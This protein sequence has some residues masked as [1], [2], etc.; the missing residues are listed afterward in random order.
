[1]KNIPLDLIKQAKEDIGIRAAEIIAGGIGLNKWDTR[2]L[3]GCC[4]VHM[5]KTPSLVWN[6][7][8]NYFKCFGC[9]ATIDIVDYYTNFRHMTFLEAAKEL[10]KEARINYDFEEFEEQKN[11]KIENKEKE[12]YKFPGPEKNTDRSK[13][14]AYLQTRGI[15]TATMD[16]RGIK[17]DARGNIVFEYRNPLGQLMTVKYRPSRKVE[18]G[19]NKT[20]C[21]KDKDTSPVLFGMDRIDTTKP[22]LICEGEIDSLACIEAG[23][24]NVVSI[25]FGAENF[26][27]IEY[28]WDW[29]EQFTK[30]VIWSDN[31]LAGEKMRSESVPRLGEYRCYVVHSKHKD[32]NIH[33]YKEGKESVLKAI[34]EAKEVPIKGITDM[35]DAPDFDINK[36]EK[37]RSGLNGLDKWISGFVLGSLNVITGYNSSGKSTIINQMCVCEPLEQGYDTFIFSNELQISQLRSWIEFQMAGPQYIKEFDNGPNQPKGYAVLNKVKGTMKDWYRGKIHVYSDEDDATAASLLKKMEEMAKKYGTK[38]FIIDNL[39]MVDLDGADSEQN[40]K[41]KEF[42]LALKRFARRYKVVV[43]LIAHPRKTDV[44]RR[45]TKL[46]IAG[47]GAITNLADYVIAV[48]R[49]TPQEKEDTK[50][51]KG[52]VIEEGCPFDNLIDLFKN[53]WTGYQDKTVGLHFDMPSKRMYGDSDDVYKKYGWTKNYKDS[54]E[55]YNE[56]PCPW[57]V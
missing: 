35:A 2:N 26:Q 32:I 31:D 12:P 52:E 27:W 44:I 17:Q 51:K 57:D 40:K 49:V 14:E 15:S 47:S 3:K 56:S 1:M 13:A 41:E 16:A 53:R 23:F 42:V 4:P 54:V 6:K 46:D 24:T 55:E 38:N 22:L 21:Q 39:M 29:L 18:K 37:I 43:H 28:N 19:E 50:N 7:K 25:P 36:T 5:E 33:L 30:I 48:H 8:G 20:W 10:F 9:G 34:N 45:L 11:K